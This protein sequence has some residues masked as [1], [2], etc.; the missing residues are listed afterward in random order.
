MFCSFYALNKQTTRLRRGFLVCRWCRLRPGI[1]DAYACDM[2]EVELRPGKSCFTSLA[3][4]EAAL[5]VRLPAAG[6]A[7]GAPALGVANAELEPDL[8]W[9]LLGSGRER[10]LPSGRRGRSSIRGTDWP[11]QSDRRAE[12]RRRVSRRTHER[13]GG[14]VARARLQEGGGRAP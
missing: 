3:A 2:C 1:R 14:R 11:R 4:S 8:W 6:R 9:R 10:C 13:S 5:A 7:G 12:S